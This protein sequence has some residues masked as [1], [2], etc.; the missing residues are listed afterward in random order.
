MEDFKIFK[1]SLSLLGIKIEDDKTAELIY[2]IAKGVSVNPDIPLSVLSDIKK[3][4]N[5]KY[6]G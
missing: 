1:L 2:E 6:N 4:I 5:I 3:Q